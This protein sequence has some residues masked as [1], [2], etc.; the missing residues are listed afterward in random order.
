MKNFVRE[1]FCKTQEEVAY[2]INEFKAKLTAENCQK[3]INK[4]KKVKKLKISGLMLF[5][6]FQ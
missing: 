1:K 4:L 5:N 6:Y 2:A 3:Y